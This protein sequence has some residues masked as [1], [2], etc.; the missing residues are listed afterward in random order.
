MLFARNN[1]IF[2][3]NFCKNWESNWGL[4]VEEVL[5][6]DQ[7]FNSSGIDFPGKMIRGVIILPAAVIQGARVN[8]NLLPVVATI[9]QPFGRHDITFSFPCWGSMPVSLKLM[10]IE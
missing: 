4:N 8:L 9:P 3:K 6:F 10:I 1:P 2:A 7:P 5:V